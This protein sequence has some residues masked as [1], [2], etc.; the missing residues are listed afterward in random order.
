ME[1]FDLILIIPGLIFLSYCMW[2]LKKGR[3][4]P[5]LIFAAFIG[6]EMGFKY[7][8][9]EDMQGYW[10]SILIYLFIA[11]VLFVVAITYF[12]VDNIH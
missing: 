1:I 11:L 6:K 7:K 4:G 10:G 3:I 8:R 2:G 5:P 12:Y 9:N